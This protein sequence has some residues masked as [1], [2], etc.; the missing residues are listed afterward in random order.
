MVSVHCVYTG[1]SRVPARG[2]RGACCSE[3]ALVRLHCGRGHLPV[4]H[5][6][7][8]DV[9]LAGALALQDTWDGRITNAVVGA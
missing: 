1:G 2:R 6:G 7:K 3:T 4:T 8:K 9:A 5:H